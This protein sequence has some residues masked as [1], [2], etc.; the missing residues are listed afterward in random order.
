M[1]GLSAATLAPE[2]DPAA[3]VGEILDHRLSRASAAPLAAAVSGGGDSVALALM[4]ADWARAAGRRLLILTVD[5]RLNPAST[6]WTRACAALAERLGAGFTAL[7]WV[8][9]KPATGLPAAARA[10]RHRL[11]AQAAR[12]AGAAVVLMGH[13]ADDLAEAAAMRQAGSTTPDPR[14]W[15]ASPA[16]PEGRGVFLLRPMLGVRRAELRAWLAARG[17]AWIEDPANGDPRFARARARAALAGG[18]LV[19]PPA[20][21]AGLADLARQVSDAQ[22]LALPR[23]ALRRAGFEAARALAGAACLCAAGTTRPP[24]G[25]RLDRL[26]EALRGGGEVVATLAG[27]RIEADA[28]QVRWMRT[29]GEIGRAGGASL[30]LAAGEAGIWDGRYAVATDEDL[31]LRPLAGRAASLSPA[32][33]KALAA[34]PAAARGGLPASES[35][36][37]CPLLEP[38]VGVRLE[39]LALPRLLAACGAVAREIG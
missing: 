18:G 36:V 13:T 23:E 28:A 26:A 6:D 9:D 17:E 27:A 11:L 8:G 33:R 2:T 1:R 34:W 16:W 15:A 37:A 19:E 30:T 22:G 24:R 14:E 25:E 29:A 38:V 31:T 39:S 32:A 10:A 35:P 4:A 5:H 20:P 3:R 12:D 7:P 21:V